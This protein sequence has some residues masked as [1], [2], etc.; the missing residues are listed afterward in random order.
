[1]RDHLEIGCTPNE[2]PCFPVGHEL[3]YR[4]AIVYKHQLERAFPGL[5]FKVRAN[6]HDF[7]TYYEVAVIYD[8]DNEASCDAAFTAE[9]GCDHWDAT[10]KLELIEMLRSHIDKN[11]NLQKPFNL[12]CEGEPLH[13]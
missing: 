8:T 5:L 2:E 7:G 6:P 13:A 4:E 1:M 12:L 11:K 9:C 3:A 10:A